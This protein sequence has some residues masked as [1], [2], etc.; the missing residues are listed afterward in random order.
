MRLRRDGFRGSV[1]HGSG[2][3]QDVAQCSPELRPLIHDARPCLFEPLQ[4]PALDWRVNYAS[5]RQEISPALRIVARMRERHI[6]ISVGDLRE[7]SI[8]SLDERIPARDVERQ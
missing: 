1:L 8:C 6:Q 5:L 7:L 3:V 4:G 2:P